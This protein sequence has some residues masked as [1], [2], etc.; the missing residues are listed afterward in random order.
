M[1]KKLIALLILFAFISGC[2]ASGE[3]T[4]CTE[5]L[6]GNYFYEQGEGQC[7][8]PTSENT[9]NY[10]EIINFDGNYHYKIIE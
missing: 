9:F 10:V 4:Y 5:K 6:N 7:A 2:L 3:Q 1:S 8:I